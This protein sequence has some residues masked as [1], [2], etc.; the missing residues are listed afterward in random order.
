MAIRSGDSNDKWYM[1]PIFTSFWNHYNQCNEW[2]EQNGHKMIEFSDEIDDIQCHNCCTSD[3]SADN[4]QKS[5]PLKSVSGGET[6]RCA[7]PLS[8]RMDTLESINENELNNS[9]KMSEDLIPFDD[10]QVLDIN[11]EYLEFVMKTKRHQIERKRIKEK[12]LRYNQRVEYVDISRFD[13]FSRKSV[14]PKRG[15]S[16]SE[17]I[18]S[19]LKNGQ[20]SSAQ[21]LSRQKMFELYGEDYNL[22][23]GMEAAL[24][25][26]FDRLCDLN[27]PKFWPIMPIRMPSKQS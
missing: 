19:S 3:T 18:Q 25:L 16:R 15:D 20:Q 12:R 5:I 21:E 1:K 22:I 7:Q 4:N 13:S 26:N 10:N 8:Q 11:E 2:L 27:Q 17:T 6:D 23:E 14:A 24:Q 9:H